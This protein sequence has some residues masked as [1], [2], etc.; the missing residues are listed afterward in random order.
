MVQVVERN[1]AFYHKGTL[2][3]RISA[4]LI[5]FLLFASLCITLPLQAA[6]QHLNLSWVGGTPADLDAGSNY[7]L[8]HV[9][10]NHQP[11]ARSFTLKM[12]MPQG[13]FSNG[14]S[15][16]SPVAAS[17]VDA[18][19]RWRECSFTLP[20]STGITTI[21]LPSRMSVCLPNP[22]QY[23][24]YLYE[25]VNFITSVQ[26]NPAGGSGRVT[27]TLT[28]LEQ[29]LTMV[30]NTQYYDDF[31]F[32]IDYASATS[33][34]VQFLVSN[35]PSIAQFDVVAGDE[36][37]E[38]FKYPGFVFVQW[39]PGYGMST[40][41]NCTSSHWKINERGAVRTWY[42]TNNVDGTI[43]KFVKFFKN[44]T[45]LEFEQWYWATVS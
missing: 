25:G 23:T 35:N 1:S 19:S 42:T 34:V 41:A 10:E 32:E 15:S 44:G 18:F 37:I 29:Y 7:T 6:G 33:G 39:C 5:A 27:C 20:A 24:A 11:Y 12:V 38:L 14:A 31:D 8:N 16:S 22:A 36:Q 45:L 3:R 4:L 28:W 9:I 21:S 17:C 30:N 40:Y 43:Y 2:M 13:W 26:I